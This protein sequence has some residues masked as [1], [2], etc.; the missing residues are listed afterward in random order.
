MPVCVHPCVYVNMFVW[1]CI[2]VVVHEHVC[3][4]ITICVQMKKETNVRH[5]PESLSLWI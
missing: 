1:I 2:H 3:A 4:C 5:L